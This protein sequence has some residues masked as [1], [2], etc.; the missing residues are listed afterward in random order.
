[1][2]ITK[3]NLEKFIEHAK[4]EAPREAVGYIVMKGRKQV[5]LSGR[6]LAA[7]PV[8][9]FATD[10]EDF[11]AAE[12]VGDVVVFLHSHA[13][14]YAT[15][16][17]SDADRQSCN[18]AGITYGIY[19]V[20]SGDYQEHEPIE[21]PLVGRFF[22]LGITDCYG[23]VMAW[24]KQ[25]GVDLDDYRQPYEWWTKGEDYFTPENFAKSGFVESDLVP[26][27]MVVMRVA[28]NT[29]NHCGVMVNYEDLLHHLPKSL[30]SRVFYR[31]SY[32]ERNEVFVVRHKDLPPPEDLKPW[33]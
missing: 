19:S 2:K 3:G 28:S 7:D 23:L 30:S 17:M 8:N 29:P 6:N 32:F 31:G 16:L 18:A 24:H 5:Y 25:Q 12:D 10:P 22:C 20:T 4:A 27:A 26:G 21:E 11:A 14:K 1:M 9:Y 15:A 33:H 13:G